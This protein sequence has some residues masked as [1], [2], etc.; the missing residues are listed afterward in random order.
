MRLVKRHY[1][2]NVKQVFKLFKRGTE[3]IRYKKFNIDF[4]LTVGKGKM[5]Y[6]KCYYS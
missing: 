3:T 4:V 5:E 6:V 1:M 2:R